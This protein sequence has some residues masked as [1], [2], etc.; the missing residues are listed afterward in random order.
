MFSSHL[1]WWLHKGKRSVRTHLWE[2]VRWGLC[3]RKDCLRQAPRAGALGK[4]LQL[5]AAW[6]MGLA[7]CNPVTHGSLELR[8]CRQCQSKQSDLTPLSWCSHSKV[9][10]SKTTWALRRVSPN[11]NDSLQVALNLFGTFRVV[12][13]PLLVQYGRQTLLSSCWQPIC[14]AQLLRLLEN[15]H[16]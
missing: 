16:F 6:A 11:E 13:W 10:F 4:A 15:L 1:V 3:M 8:P 9:L 2:G 7:L 5:S 12:S 14:R